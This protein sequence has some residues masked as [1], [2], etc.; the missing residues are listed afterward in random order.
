VPTTT[1]HF[2]AESL[3]RIDAAAR[4]RGISRNRFVIEAC[5]KEAS[6]DA[7]SWSKGFFEHAVSPAD[8]VRLGEAVNEMEAAIMQSR[9][10]R[11]APLI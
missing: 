6:S 7:G 10:S 11:G 3:R 5:E 9:S 8:R 2:P 4:R 1:V